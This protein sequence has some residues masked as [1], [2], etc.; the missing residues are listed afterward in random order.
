MS[1]VVKFMET[2]SRMVITRGSGGI[3]G[4]INGYGVSVWKDEKDLRLCGWWWLQNNV[5]VF[6]A[7][8]LFT[9]KWL[10]W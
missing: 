6:N 10:K 4:I 7:T 3:G 2:E 8:E 5:S 9:W 1:R